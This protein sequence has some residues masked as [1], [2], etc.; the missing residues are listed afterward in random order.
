MY[1]SSAVSIEFANFNVE[2]NNC[3]ANMSKYEKILDQHF[4]VLLF[5]NQGEKVLKTRKTTG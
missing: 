1:H 2:S 5:S 3:P 4:N